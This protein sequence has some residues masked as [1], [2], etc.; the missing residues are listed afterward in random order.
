MMKKTAFIENPRSTYDPSLDDDEKN[1]PNPFP[2]KMALAIATIEKY[3]LPSHIKRTKKA[4]KKAVFL[5]Q[6]EVLTV[7]SVD[8]TEK[9]MQQLKDFLHQLFGEGITKLEVKQ[10]KKIAA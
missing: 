9:Q 5:P 8:P 3:G 10:K 7:F 1:N 6:T 2:E 4:A